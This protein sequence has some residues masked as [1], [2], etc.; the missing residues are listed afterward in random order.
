MDEVFKEDDF[1]ETLVP[2]GA[3]PRSPSP[4]L[5]AGFVTFFA[6]SSRSGLGG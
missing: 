3:L 6:F 1:N 4:P 5:A 2:G